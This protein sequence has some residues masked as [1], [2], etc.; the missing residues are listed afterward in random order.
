MFKITLKMA[1]I[2]SGLSLDQAA[3]IGGI[4][5]RTLERWEQDSSKSHLPSAMRLLSA[6][7]TTMEHVRFGKE[8]DILKELR[9]KLDKVVD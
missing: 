8:E 5:K 2:N 1:R 7:G 4:T 6:Y 3:E 9:M